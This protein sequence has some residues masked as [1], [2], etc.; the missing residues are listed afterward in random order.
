MTSGLVTAAWKAVD[1]PGWNVLLRTRVL[2]MELRGFIILWLVLRC[3]AF[4]V[5]HD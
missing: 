3:P 5:L 1:D 4:S 2:K